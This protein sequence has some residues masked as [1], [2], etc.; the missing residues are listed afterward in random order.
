MR[1]GFELQQIHS[2]EAVVR[3]R[4]V[5][6]KRGYGKP[7]PLFISI[8]CLVIQYYFATVANHVFAPISFTVGESL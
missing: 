3:K 5:E 4:V 8:V 7:D 2:G 1:Y 6:I